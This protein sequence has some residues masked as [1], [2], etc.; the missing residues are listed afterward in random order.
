MD[1]NVS[2]VDRLDAKRLYYAIYVADWTA[3]LLPLSS[4]LTALIKYRR[5]VKQ[6]LLDRVGDFHFCAGLALAQ[7]HHR[8]FNLGAARGNFSV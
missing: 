4:A 2:Q 5:L 6:R 8:I 7:G 1:L 3:G